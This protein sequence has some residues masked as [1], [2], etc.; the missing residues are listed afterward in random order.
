MENEP[1]SDTFYDIHL[2]AF[3]ISHPYLHIFLERFDINA[4]V[5]S[6]IS[7]LKNPFRI[8]VYTFLLWIAWA[9]AFIPRLGSRLS[10]FIMKKINPANNLISVMENDVGSFFLLI[11]NCLRE[12]GR[13]DNKGLMVSGKRYSRIV[14]TPLMMDF[15]HRRLDIEKRKFH[16]NRL[17]KKPIGEQIVDVSNAIKKYKEFEYTDEFEKQFPSLKLDDSGENTKRL[18][19]I[20]PFLG[21]NTKNYKSEE[22]IRQLLNKYFAKYKGSR[23]D[24]FNSMGSLNYDNFFAGVKLYPPLDFDPWPEDNEIELRKVKCLYEYCMEKK[25]PITIHSPDSGWG[26]LPKKELKQITSISK[27][28]KVLS[29]Y[30]ELKLNLAHFPIL[31]KRLKVLE[32]TRLEQIVDLV[33]RYQH[34]YVDFANR[35]LKEKYYKEL[36]KYIN[37]KPTTLGNKLKSRILFGSD[38]PINLMSIDSY[39]EY[40]GVFSESSSIHDLKEQFC[41][42]NPE[43]F[44]FQT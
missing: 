14:L 3:N 8:I 37:K 9:A 11:E 40:V 17:S 22:A 1:T 28:G 7:S 18:F 2:H 41:S 12:H 30:K 24:M 13:L 29:N 31:E 25:L 16:Y 4:R 39:E 15:E 38:F 21:I 36:I 23:Q 32:N 35:A 5:N 44:L 34:V 19:E 6:M 42:V 20:Y 10:L 33:S 43:R 26:V 27:W